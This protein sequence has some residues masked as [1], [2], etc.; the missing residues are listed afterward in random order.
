MLIMTPAS[1]ESNSYGFYLY[2]NKRKASPDSEIEK[3][4]M[5]ARSISGIALTP[6]SLS[7]CFFLSVSLSI[8]KYLSFVFQMIRTIKMLYGE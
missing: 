1:G 5:M 2:D 6:R 7:L 8:C 4:I 3:Y